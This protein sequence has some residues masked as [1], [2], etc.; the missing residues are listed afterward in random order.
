M[1]TQAEFFAEKA[2]KLHKV[3]GQ[4]GYEVKFL[5]HFYIMFANLGPKQCGKESAAPNSWK[6]SNSLQSTSAFGKDPNSWKG[7]DF[8]KGKLYIIMAFVLSFTI[9]FRID[10]MSYFLIFV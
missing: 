10:K 3:V 6:D 4:F 9:P 2:N 5:T 1:F 7:I 8:W